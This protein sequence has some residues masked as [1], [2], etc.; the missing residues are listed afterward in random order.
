MV[1]LM[2]NISDA[3]LKPSL[4]PGER[5]GTEQVTFLVGFGFLAVPEANEY[6]GCQVQQQ[7][8]NIN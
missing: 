5:L 6:H 1:P 3:S 4:S 8:Y 2:S 7:D